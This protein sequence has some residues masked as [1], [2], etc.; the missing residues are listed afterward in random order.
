MRDF[1]GEH[2]IL[3]LHCVFAGEPRWQANGRPQHAGRY[4]ADQARRFEQVNRPAQ[5][6][7]AGQFFDAL[8]NGRVGNRL[9]PMAQPAE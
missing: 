8:V 7:P 5:T 9:A 4:R 1:V 2:D 6:H 3:L